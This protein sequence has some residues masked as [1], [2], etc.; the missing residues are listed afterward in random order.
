[1]YVRA[2]VF[3]CVYECVCCC[4]YLLLCV[5]VFGLRLC[6]FVFMC[7]CV[8]MCVYECAYVCSFVCSCACMCMRVPVFI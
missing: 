1:M 4:A 6:V 8:C 3:I 5:G 2:S 7:V